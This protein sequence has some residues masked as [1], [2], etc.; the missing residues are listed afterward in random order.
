MVGAAD[1]SGWKPNFAF[2]AAEDLVRSDDAGFSPLKTSKP[3]QAALGV[4]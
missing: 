4:A 3:F 1:F 2:N